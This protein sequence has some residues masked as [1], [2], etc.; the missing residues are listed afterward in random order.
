MSLFQIF[1]KN[2]WKQFLYLLFLF[3]PLIF[4][5]HTLSCVISLPPLSPPSCST[6]ALGRHLTTP[7]NTCISFTNCDS[8]WIIAQWRE[9]TTPPMI[10]NLIQW[11]HYKVAEGAGKGQRPQPYW[12]KTEKLL[13]SVNYT[14]KK[15]K[16]TYN[17]LV[18]PS[19]MS[20]WTLPLSS[21]TFWWI[22]SGF[23]LKPW[24]L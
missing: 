22:I 2:I 11:H 4:H 13:L 15:T 16:Y 1:Y 12:K 20:F 17:T 21:C 14:T 5:C 19:V 6:K 8:C 3:Y 10:I 18:H 7:G 24:Y 23:E 9:G